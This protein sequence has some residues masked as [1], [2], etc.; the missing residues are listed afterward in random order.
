MD[1]GNFPKNITEHSEKAE[2]IHNKKEEEAV[3]VEAQL[4]RK[5]QQFF[6]NIVFY[7]NLA[8]LQCRGYNF[9]VCLHI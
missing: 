7:K 9:S 4:T 1:H 5:R 6:K 8:V 3:R 2:D